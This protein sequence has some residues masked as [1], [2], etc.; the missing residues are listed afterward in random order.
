MKKRIISIMFFCGL[1]AI[2]SQAQSWEPLLQQL[3]DL[4]DFEEEQWENIIEILTE[5]QQHPMNVNTATTDDFRQIPFLNDQEIEDIEEYRYRYGMISSLGELAM[6]PSISYHKR[7]LLHYFLCAEPIQEKNVMPKMKDLLK[8]GKQQLLLNGKVPFYK[9][10]GDEQG[11]LGYPYRHQIRYQ[12]QYGDRIKVG[13]VG[14]QDAGEPFFAGKNAMG[15]DHYSYYLQMKKMGIVENL[16][17]GKYRLNI[18]A[19]LVVNNG[20]SFGKTALL[21]GM[22]NNHTTIRPHSSSSSA[23]CLQGIA[24]TL[25]INKKTALDLFLSYQQKDATLNKDSQSVSTILTSGYHR[26]KAEMDKKGN[27]TQQV[28]GT[29]LSYEYAHGYVGLSG[30]YIGLSLPL[31]PDTNIVYRKY[32][33]KG[34]HFFHLSTDYQYRYGR[35]LFS[36]ETAISQN[37]HLATLNKVNISVA[38]P[39]DISIIQRFYSKKYTS[40]LSKGFSEGGRVQNESGI[41]ISANYHPSRN[42]ILSYYTDYAYFA[43]PRYQVSAASHTWDH[44]LSLHYQTGDWTFQMRYRLRQKQK[45]DEQSQ[46]MTVSEHKGKIG[47]SYQKPKWSSELYLQSA[48][49]INEKKHNG[50]LIGNNTVIQPT[51]KWKINAQITYY[52]TDD[53]DSRLYQY[54]HGPLYGS[55]FSMFSGK[56]IRY[57]FMIR[58][59][60]TRRWMICGKIGTTDYFDRHT[61]GSGYQQVD[62]SSITD[63]EI[64][65]RL[66]W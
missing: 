57:S 66:K 4:E 60:P 9:R 34:R 5:L 3:T 55:S 7:Q 46:L 38:E 27:I 36:G 28:A 64:Q 24:T 43:W 52:N 23:N 25:K 56:G 51:E 39:L 12:Y 32:Y 10:K 40:L 63:M 30:V 53:F 42:L 58:F 17:V 54:E 59:E 37:M 13:I 21:S 33:A 61:I 41:Y 16:I 22:E 18:G 44:L 26:T 62:R 49:T 1:F 31:N 45:D 15:Y 8:Y 14:A 19:G 47:V 48:H 35:F 11:Y 29:R 6:I 2:T 65:V 50:F 20:M